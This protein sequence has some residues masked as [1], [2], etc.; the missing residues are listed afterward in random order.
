MKLTFQQ[1]CPQVFQ[2]QIFESDVW[3]ASLELKACEQ[4]MLHAPSGRGKTSFIYYLLGLRYDYTGTILIDDRDIRTFTM[5]QWTE[6][7]RTKFAVVYQDLQLFDDLTVKENI[8]MLPQF[9]RNCNM[10]R[11]EEF[12]GLLGIGQKWTSRT[13]TLSFGQ[14]QRV[15]LVRS[16][17]KPFDYLICDE[18]FSHLDIANTAKCID[19]IKSRV[20]EESAGL[21][22]SALDETETFDDIK[23]IHL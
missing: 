1:L 20:K 8:A 15:A 23:I 13:G 19:L 12:I 5:D 2:N 11:A 18:P 22:L 3:N 14:K 6:I 17:L 10:K 9:G 4:I 21:I 16:L 7:R